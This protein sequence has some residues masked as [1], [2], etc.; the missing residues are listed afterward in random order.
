MV[1]A[2]IETLWTLCPQWHHRHCTH[3]YIMD[4]VPTMASRTLRHYGH[5]THYDSTDIATIATLWTLCPLCH[6][7]HCNIMGIAPT[8]TS[9]EL[10]LLWHYGQCAHYSTS[11]SLC[12]LLRHYRYCVYITD[13]VPTIRHHC[14]CACYY[15]IIDIVSTSRTL[16]PL[17]DITVIVPATTT[18]Y[19]LCLHHG[20]C[21]HYDITDLGPTIRQWQR[22]EISLTFF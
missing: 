15:D 4:I 2:P 21:A 17:Y 3:W 9:R 6:H 19:T 1:I 18:F 12:L 11:L 13:I 7:G 20:H 10:R 16:C 14:H 22:H 8:M 5:C